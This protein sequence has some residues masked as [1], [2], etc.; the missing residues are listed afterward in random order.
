MLNQ[1]SNGVENEE[2]NLE[3]DTSVQLVANDNYLGACIVAAAFI[4]AGAWIYTSGPRAAYI[5]S[6]KD[7]VQKPEKSE[8]EE[9][10]LPTDG[11]VLPISW[12][13]LGAKMVSVGVIDAQKFEQLYAGRGGL[14]D[15]AKGLL[16]GENNGNIEITSENSGLLLNLLWALGLGNKNNILESDEMADPRYGGAENFASTG[17]WTLSRGNAMEHYSRHPFIVLTPEQQALVDKVSRGIYRPCCGNSTHFPDC[18][19][20][21]AMLGLLELMASQGVDEQMMYKAALWVNAYWF[22]D[23]YL[24]IARYLESKNIDWSDVDPKEILGANYSSAQGFQQ[25]LRKVGPTDVQKGGS[26]CGVDAGAPQ[27]NPGGCGV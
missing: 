21:M 22:P 10:V 26:R 12:G 3:S 11:A 6:S 2:K 13:D 25:I 18:N 8:F 27:N 15:K 19:H 20:G 4:I 14:D 16:Y 7:T 5:S 9:K 24:T 1:V 23:T 17:G